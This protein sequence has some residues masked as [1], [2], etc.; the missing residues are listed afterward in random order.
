MMMMALTMMMMAARPASWARCRRP[1]WEGGARGTGCANAIAKF[2]SACHDASFIMLIRISEHMCEEGR[3]G[4]STTSCGF[5]QRV[6][7]LAPTSSAAPPP[8][9]GDARLRA[10]PREF[11]CAHPVVHGA[12]ATLKVARPMN[13]GS[14]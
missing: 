6:A 3:Y 11:S 5:S 8:Q 10:A 7:V 2:A 14:M 4:G 9:A 1:G 12:A 13:V